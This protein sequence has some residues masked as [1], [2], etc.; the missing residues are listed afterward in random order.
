MEV[1]YIEVSL[2]DYNS[3]TR[4]IKKREK[5]IKN[6]KDEISKLERKHGCGF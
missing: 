6:L 1:K 3:K 2:E 4:L 5:E